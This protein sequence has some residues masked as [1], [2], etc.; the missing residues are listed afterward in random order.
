MA[1]ARFGGQKKRFVIYKGLG[2]RV[3]QLPAAKCS[4][5]RPTR[6]VLGTAH[7]LDPFI[8]SGGNTSIKSSGIYLHRFEETPTK[9]SST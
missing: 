2:C 3:M 6:L 7:L 1:A 5:I 4:G 9:P 8:R